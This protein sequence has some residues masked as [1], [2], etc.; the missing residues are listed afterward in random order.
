MAVLWKWM[1]NA[2]RKDAQ[3]THCSCVLDPRRVRRGQAVDEE[4]NA[5]LATDAIWRLVRILGSVSLLLHSTVQVS[6][7]TTTRTAGQG[8]NATRNSGIARN[9]TK[10]EDE[11]G[12]GRRRE[13]REEEDE[14]GGGRQRRRLSGCTMLI[15]VYLLMGIALAM[16][17]VF[18]CGSVWEASVSSGTWT[19]EMVREF[20]FM[21]IPAI[22]SLWM[23]TT[24]ETG[25]K[26]RCGN[27]TMKSETRHLPTGQPSAAWVAAGCLLNRLTRTCAW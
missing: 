1:M 9:L 15:T 7:A 25:P 11:D 23:A 20:G 3:C 13:K 21:R 12:G 16:A 19:L 17:S 5:K 6:L 24:S 8:S 18:R 27:A 10:K 2:L 14:D 22:A 4:L 26:C